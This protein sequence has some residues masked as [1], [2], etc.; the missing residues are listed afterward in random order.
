MA[1]NGGPSEIGFILKNPEFGAGMKE[2]GDI[3]FE[4]RSDGLGLAVEF[5]G[6]VVV[7]F[8]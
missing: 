1:E 6:V 8:A 7:D 2:D 4:S 3:F 5:D